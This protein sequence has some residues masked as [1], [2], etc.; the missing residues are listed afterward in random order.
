MKRAPRWAKQ[1]LKFTYTDGDFESADFITAFDAQIA[2]RD[3]E[4]CTRRNWRECGDR[5]KGVSKVFR[6]ECGGDLIGTTVAIRT[7][8]NDNPRADTFH[9][10]LYNAV[11]AQEAVLEVP[12]G[13]NAGQTM[14]NAKKLAETSATDLRNL[15]C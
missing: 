10:T 12:E 14:R 1:G 7:A 5:S 8:H 11:S 3:N 2:L 9:V 15:Y 4:E 6:A 13:K